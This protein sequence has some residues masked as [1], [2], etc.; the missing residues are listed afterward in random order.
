[1]K[2]EA[3][4]RWL[5]FVVV[6]GVAAGCKRQPGADPNTLA[7]IG[8]RVIAQDDFIKRYQDFRRRT[9]GGVPDHG[10]ARRQVL[11]NYVEEELLI[12][13]AIQRGYAED[14][15]GRHEHE[16]LEI[17]ELLNAFN[18]TRI[19]S[20]V[21][22]SEAELRQLYVRL[23]TQVQA[24]HLYAPTRAQADSLYAA[25]QNGATFEAL[26]A[27]VFQDPVLRNSGGLLGN[28]S[29]DEMEPAQV[30]AVGRHFFGFG[31]VLIS[32]MNSDTS[33]NSL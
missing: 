8:E 31:S 12:T 20:K 29:V 32:C 22:V 15:A 10:E 33:R 27:T 7:V 9:G 26:A 13:A 1:M 14:A 24:R 4:G 2:R 16:R 11:Q 6:S 23:H 28:F 21:R 5:L 17:Q 3:L 18:R 30:V 19:A 25:L